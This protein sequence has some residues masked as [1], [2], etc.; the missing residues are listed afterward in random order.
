M[1]LTCSRVIWLE[2]L[3]HFLIKLLI[4]TCQGDKFSRILQ[5]FKK[6]AKTTLRNTWL[7][8]PSE[9]IHPF[10]NF[11]EVAIPLR[12]DSNS[13]RQ[14]KT[15][16]NNACDSALILVVQMKMIMLIQHAEKKEK[17][18]FKRYAMSKLSFGDATLV[19]D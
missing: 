8:F 4:A 3:N 14:L 10:E 5:V 17:W 9:K 13:N 7:N 1:C 16:R 2:L 15:D 19:I 18:S 12:I 6:H 11:V